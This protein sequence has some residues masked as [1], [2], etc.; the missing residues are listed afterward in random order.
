MRAASSLDYQVNRFGFWSVIVALLTTVITLFFPLDIPDGFSAEHAD[1]IVWLNENRGVFIFAWVNQIFAMFSLSA[2][3]ACSAWS[4][5]NKPLLAILALFFVAMSTMAFIIPKFIAVWTIPMLADTVSAGAGSTEMADSLLL[6]L[7]VSVPFSLYTSF[8][9]LGFWLYS[10]FALLAAVPLYGETR[11]AK[12][13]AVMLGLFGVVYQIL[14][15][16]LLL[17][18]LAPV[19]IEGYFMGV[20][21]LL[22]LYMIPMAFVFK[23]ST[24]S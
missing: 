14:L 19:E 5:R 24:S 23:N 2:V 21:M 11:S 22:L 15:I 13:A 12:V 20:A 8:D 10:V 1:R 17:G 16:A 9:Y 3:L 7:N 18:A 6:L 4:A